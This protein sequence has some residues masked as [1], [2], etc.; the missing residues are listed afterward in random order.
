MS[1]VVASAREGIYH[2]ASISASDAELCETALPFLTD[3]LAARE[4]TYVILGPHGEG[5]VRRELGEPAGLHYVPAGV[6][7]VNPA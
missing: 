2:E 4:P 1:A 5:L 3:G 6:A 7:Y